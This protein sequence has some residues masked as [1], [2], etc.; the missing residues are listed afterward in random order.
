MTPA[1]FFD[2]DKTLLRIDS[3]VRWIR[4]ALGRGQVPYSIAAR[5]VGLGIPQKIGVIPAQPGARPGGRERGYVPAHKGSAAHETRGQR[6]RKQE[7]N[8]QGQQ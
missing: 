7:G 2:L 5:A 6:D 4:F 3:G 8:G 1:A